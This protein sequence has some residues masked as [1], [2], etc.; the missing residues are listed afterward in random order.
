MI[1]LLKALRLGLDNT[2]IQDRTSVGEEYTPPF[3][4]EGVNG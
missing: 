3:D 1:V 4:L 2:Y